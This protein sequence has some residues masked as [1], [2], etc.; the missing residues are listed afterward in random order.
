MCR[1]FHTHPACTDT[2]RSLQAL[3]ERACTVPPASNPTAH[4]PAPPST[5][6]KSVVSG[7]LE[8]D[9][10]QIE[11]YPGDGGHVASLQDA[12]L[13]S[14]EFGEYVV[15]TTPRQ[16]GTV[17]VDVEVLDAPAPLDPARDDR[18]PVP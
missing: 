8:V 2:A 6:L 17:T 9:Y 3:S 13:V 18:Q 7:D 4:P 12:G 5:T 16:Y 11:L 15:L 10:S 1:R 14:G